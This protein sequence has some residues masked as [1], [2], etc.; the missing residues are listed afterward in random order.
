MKWK[1]TENGG[2]CRHV[3]HLRQQCHNSKCVIFFP[4]EV[5]KRFWSAI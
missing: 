2:A 4:G 5:F 3:A 1:T